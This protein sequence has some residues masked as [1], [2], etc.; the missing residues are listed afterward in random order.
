MVFSRAITAQPGSGGTDR[1]ARRALAAARRACML[2]CMLGCG[3]GPVAPAAGSEPTWTTYHRD[4]GRS[5]DDPDASAAS[6]PV[7]AWHSRDLG[8]PI[9]GQP[10]ILGS[11]VFVATV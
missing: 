11:R 4:P 1:Y 9:W 5:G 3:L 8:A 7:E 10:L 6:A 2:G